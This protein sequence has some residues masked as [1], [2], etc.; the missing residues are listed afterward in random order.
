MALL[1]RYAGFAPVALL[2]FLSLAPSYLR[3][4]LLPIGLGQLEHLGAY[5]TVSL[6][7]AIAYRKARAVIVIISI[8][9]PACAALFEIA[10][11]WLPGRDP[12]FSD[13]AASALGTW[14]GAWSWQR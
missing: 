11:I 5:A 4:H 6:L 2:A 8:G 10:Q 13:F 3:P 7:L 12:K 14:I 9:L 1:L